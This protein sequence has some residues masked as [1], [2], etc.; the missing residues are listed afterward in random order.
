MAGEPILIVDDNPTNLKLVR[1][2]LAAE[3]YLVKTADDAEEAL[4]TLETFTPTLI[5]TDLQLPGMDGLTLVR[6]LRQDA[7]WA[8]TWIVA[9]TA[10]A[11]KGDEE[12][13]LAA[14]CDGYLTK[15]IDSE[16][17]PIVVASFATRPRPDP[18][19]RGAEVTQASDNRA[20]TAK[21]VLIVDD[22]PLQ[23]KLS[24][25]RLKDAGYRVT[26]AASAVEALSLALADPPDAIF[27]D[28]LMGE[29]DGFGLCR[30]LREQPSLADVPIVLASAHYWDDKAQALAEN[31][32]AAALIGRT[33][34]FHAE[35]KAL[36]GVFGRHQ[37]A[38]NAAQA[39]VYEQ[40][41]RMNADQISRL[42]GEAKSAEGRYRALFE[43]ADDAIA[44]LDRSG[45]ILEANQRWHTFLGVDP[46]TM[47]GR[48]LFEFAPR[49]RETTGA[50]LEAA[51]ERGSG[52]VYAV[53]IQRP[54]GGTLYVDFALSALDVGSQP[55]VFAIGRDVTGRFLAAQQLATA[56]EKYR[57][58]VERMPDIVMTTSQMRCVFVTSNVERLTGFAPSEVYAME[59]QAWL[60]R[61][62]PDDEERFQQMARK[63]GAEAAGDYFDLE[64]RFRRKDGVWIWLWHRVIGVY[65]RNGERYSD[66]LISDI[67]QRRKL[68]E[69]LRQA[70][71]MEAVG[72]LTGG[73]AHDFNNILGTILANSEF[74]IDELGEKDPRLEDA[75]EIKLAAQRAA[76]LTRQLLAFS[77]KQVLEL[78]VTE[79]NPIISNVERML[80]RLIGEDIELSVRLCNDL[81]KVQIDQGQ[82]EQ[83]LLN[84]AVN[85]RD[86]MPR[87]GKLLIETAN[88]GF[89]T[90]SGGVG[91]GHYVVITVTDTGV[92]MD[93]ET[94]QRIFEPFFTT[95]ELGKGT[96]LGLATSHGIVAQSGG[97]ITVYS[98]LGRG[99]AFKVYLPRV[100]HEQATSLQPATAGP[101]G[102]NE[103]LL[104]VE[105][106]VPLRG[107]I[108]RML[109]S[110]G[111]RVLAAKDVD[112]AIQLATAHSG[113][114]A[115]L[116]ADVVMPKLSGPELAAQVSARLA[117]VKVLF[118]SGYTDHAAFGPGMIDDTLRFIQKPFTPLALAR[119]V[120][121]VLEE[122]PLLDAPV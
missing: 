112:E 1:V 108:R 29:T 9:L 79:L 42:L 106:D 24:K 7:R 96:G 34:E 89:E 5:L 28:V 72:Q 56:E 38:S 25:L 41:L 93:A 36:A 90:R 91:P 120:R 83:V 53:P 26:T 61:V 119:K 110:F 51:I 11:M 48:R 43:T 116:I 100:G 67:T 97:Y 8:T 82:I 30:R 85:A 19:A 32:G 39:A 16:T 99:T 45:V 114:I 6:R 86:A 122:P 10:Y 14:G 20:T 63:H 94:Q 81:G 68:E 101:I 105:D 104:L 69:S 21:R 84:L 76:A 98:E 17:L 37:P 18:L 64:Y 31:V 12:K 88:V 109:S 118:M 117:G 95:K 2:I 13:A 78:R 52:R 70:Q 113:E 103:V 15:P 73:I 80:R 50:E 57:S 4:A 111:Y 46:T 40:H 62:H 75:N 87:G 47:V 65:E 102:G 60:E 35:L 107:A 71:K 77:R 115:L 54:N 74:L 55:L 59:Q 22:D 44:V 121:E 58:L 3:G 49:G 92:G 33:P 27:S 66:G 23:L